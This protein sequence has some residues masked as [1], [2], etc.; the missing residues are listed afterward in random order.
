MDQI[1]ALNL[2]NVYIND[3][4]YSGKLTKNNIEDA[5]NEQQKILTE[6]NSI[7][8]GIDDIIGG[9]DDISLQLGKNV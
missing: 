9:V 1:K 3:L 4:T 2:L 7:K 8:K 6:I 5:K